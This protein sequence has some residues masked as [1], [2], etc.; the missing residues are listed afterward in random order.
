[1][2]RLKRGVVAA[3]MHL[4]GPTKDDSSSSVSLHQG[5]NGGQGSW[6]L[7]VG[8]WQPGGQ[9]RGTDT[10]KEQR[11]GEPGI[12]DIKCLGGLGLRGCPAGALLS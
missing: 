12:A 6:Q 3:A 9:R 8:S 5:F 1:M 7:V 10:S 11:N 4:A 2:H